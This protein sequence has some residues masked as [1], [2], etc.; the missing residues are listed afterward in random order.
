METTEQEREK[1]VL[2][3]LDKLP[4]ETV[5]TLPRYV[6]ELPYRYRDTYLTRRYTDTPPIR[7]RRSIK[8]IQ[9]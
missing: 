2:A 6:P 5:M 1:D 8:K 4:P 9:Q 3:F 7:Y